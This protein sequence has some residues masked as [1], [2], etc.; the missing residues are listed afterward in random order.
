MRSVLG[1]GGAARTSTRS[2]NGL[3][4]LLAGLAL[5]AC[6]L[7]FASPL[8][9]TPVNPAF[10]GNPLN[11]S[12]LLNEAQATNTHTPS[13][14][15]GNDAGSLAPETPLQQFNDQLQ[16]SILSQ[17][18]ASATSS[19]LGPDGV[20]KPGI[21]QTSNFTISIVDAGGGLL[22]ITTTDKQT[23]ATTSFQVSQAQP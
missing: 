13:G 2:R 18:A 10:G 4:A 3:G 16:S 1:S 6:P 5:A 22:N 12:Y 19:I 23:G 15:G 21:V 14:G 9:Y 20:L 7:A 17:L 11:G 8:I